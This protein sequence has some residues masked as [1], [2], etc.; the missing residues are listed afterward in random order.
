MRCLQNPIMTSPGVHISQLPFA[1]VCTNAVSV[2][3]YFMPTANSVPCADCGIPSCLMQPTSFRIA[4]KQVPHRCQTAFRFASCITR[5]L[6]GS[7]WASHPDYRVELREDILDEKDGPILRH[8]LQGLH[9]ARILLPRQQIDQPSQEL[10]AER[11]ERF[12]KAG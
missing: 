11:Y 6:T 9:K 8:G 10:L 12:R 7:C 5:R 4:R 3:G 2:N 1:S